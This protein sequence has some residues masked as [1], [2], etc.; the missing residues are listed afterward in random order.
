MIRRF[1]AWM[2]VVAFV[3]GLAAPV[4]AQQQTT[5]ATPAAAAKPAEP[6]KPVAKTAAAKPKA[7]TGAIKTVSAES[8]TVVGA[9]K[10]E[11]TFAVD[12]DTKITKGGKAVEA[13]TLAE[14]EQVTVKYAEADG[15]MTAKSIEVKAAKT[16]AKKPQPKPQS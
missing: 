7:A 12:K 10:K 16:T 3:V 13:K 15:K 1:S 6:A 14:K 4:L 9:D 8:I 5:P 2:V 11:W